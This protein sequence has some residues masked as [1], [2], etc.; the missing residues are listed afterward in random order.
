MKWQS[1]KD[2]MNEK[3]WMFMKKRYTTIKIP[4]E[5][6]NRIYRILEETGEPLFW[7]ENNSIRDFILNRGTIDKKWEIGKRSKEYIKR[8]S[9]LPLYLTE[10]VS[11]LLEVYSTVKKT[12]KSNVVISA[13]EKE[14]KKRAVQMNIEI[15]LEYRRK[16]EH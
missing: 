12:T 1:K 10:D 3:G 15:N 6:K 5:L 14:C 16:D 7:F 11:N 9:M 4:E 2:I 13:L 8:K